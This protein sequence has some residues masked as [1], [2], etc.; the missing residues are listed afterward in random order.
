MLSELCEYKEK[1]K[2]LCGMYVDCLFSLRYIQKV[3]TNYLQGCYEGISNE[4]ADET[5]ECKTLMVKT[6]IN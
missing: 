6:S 5:A 2:Y 3:N 4:D 1:G